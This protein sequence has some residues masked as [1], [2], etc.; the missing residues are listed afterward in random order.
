M[1]DPNQVPAES[2][3]AKQ[4][5]LKAAPVLVGGL[6]ALIALLMVIQFM[7]AVQEDER[8]DQVRTLES[9]GVENVQQE[10]EDEYIGNVGNCTLRIRFENWNPERVV[11]YTSEGEGWNR[12]DYPIETIRLDGNYTVESTDAFE[13]AGCYT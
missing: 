4:W 13:D 8:R 9:M 3:S 7:P 12:R 6:L 2:S 10:S 5:I 1:S 11:F